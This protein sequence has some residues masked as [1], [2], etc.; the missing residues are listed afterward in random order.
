MWDEYILTEKGK[1]EYLIGICK[2]D[3]PVSDFDADFLIDVSSSW[4]QFRDE[5][6]LFKDEIK[7]IES[8][9]SSMG[10]L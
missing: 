2:G 5:L 4:R 8:I 6:A 7:S 10:L 3:Y 1:V 9:A